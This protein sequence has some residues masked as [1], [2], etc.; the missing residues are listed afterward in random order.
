MP[1]QEDLG[2]S[3]SAVGDTPGVLDRILLNENTGPV[4][5][6]TGQSLLDFGSKMRYGLPADEKYARLFRG[7]IPGYENAKITPD[8]TDQAQRALSVASGAER[9]GPL[10]PTIMSLMSVDNPAVANPTSAQATR[11]ALNAA[12]G[13]TFDHDKGRKSKGTAIDVADAASQALADVITAP[14]RFATGGF[15][16]K[17]PGVRDLQYKG[18]NYLMD[19]FGATPEGPTK[20]G[21]FLKDL[22]SGF[23]GNRREEPV[24]SFA[25]PRG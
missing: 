3:R 15:Y 23:G 4:L 7:G 12:Q 20:G 25:P 17:I 22:L 5:E 2:L 9:F 18:A 1:F 6:Q 19:L 11:D 10:L 21:S 24:V 14:A 13:G 8:N 16:E